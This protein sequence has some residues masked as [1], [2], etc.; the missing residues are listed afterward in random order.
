LIGAGITLL[1][2]T[3]KGRKILKNLKT[4]GLGR[5]GEWEQLVRDITEAL[6]DDIAGVD[7][8]TVKDRPQRI[9]KVQTRIEPKT[10]IDNQPIEAE[11]Q[12]IKSSTKRF[13]RGVRK[14]IT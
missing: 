7:D 4:E 2:T 3:R 13:F 14:K 5:F 1:F 12:R 9:K 6:D 11:V 10:S 8:Y